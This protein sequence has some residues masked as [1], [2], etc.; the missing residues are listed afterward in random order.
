MY[1][2]SYL[3][4]HQFSR[5]LL[6][7]LLYFSYHSVHFITVVCTP[8]SPSNIN[9]TVIT[10]HGS[11]LIATISWSSDF[12]VQV[13]RYIVYVSRADDPTTYNGILFINDEK[14]KIVSDLI[15]Y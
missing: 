4:N 3:E 6:F 12:D 7:A 2:Y 14:Y 11:D 15:S 8:N 9:F 1:T 13:S 5:F 10:L